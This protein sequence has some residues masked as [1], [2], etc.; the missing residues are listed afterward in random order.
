VHQSTLGFP[1]F[2]NGNYGGVVNLTTSNSTTNG[3]VNST[4]YQIGF[5][6]KK[7]F[8]YAISAYG[9]STNT[10]DLT[11]DIGFAFSVS[12]KTAN[13]S[14]TCTGAQ[15]L[16]VND[17]ASFSQKAFS[18][19]PPSWIPNI[20]NGIADKDYYYL[21]VAALPHG[22]MGGTQTASL[23]AIQIVETATL[24]VSPATITTN[25]SNNTPQTFIVNNPNGI[26][27]IQSYTWALGQTG[28]S[29]GWLY[30]GSAAPTTIT[31]S[32]NSIL[33][34]PACRSRQ[35]NI[36]V[37][38][39]LNGSSYAATNLVQVQNVPGI[40]TISGT[41]V[42]CSGSANYSVSNNSC[43]LPLAWSVSPTGIA[44]LSCN[45]CNTTTLTRVSNGTVTLSAS[46]GSNNNNCSSG[47]KSVS[48]GGAS[49]PTSITVNSS[50]IC[51]EYRFTT[52]QNLN[53]T[54]FTWQ[55]H[56]NPFSNNEEVFPNLPYTTRLNIDQGNGSYNIGVTAVNACGSSSIYYITT[57]IT[58]G[59]SS[60]AI[61][62]SPDPTTGIV[63][64]LS[65]IPALT[66]NTEISKVIR[67]SKIYHIKVIG[68]MGNLLKQFSYPSGITKTNIDLSSLKD[69]IYILQVYDNV[70]WTSKQFV[71]S[72]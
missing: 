14:T 37:S 58:C 38:A 49:Q 67:G 43:G 18:V 64:V 71:I 15:L 1:S 28:V 16:S 21:I 19:S 60:Q 27:G 66:Q 4:Q 39:T 33:L 50:D 25:C 46:I 42:I 32:S 70:S 11:A 20:V 51:D 13:T 59:L 41:S 12:A 26:S 52:N 23:Q 17:E 48:V 2:T 7:G 54:S 56:K 61:K 8:N 47:S 53:A 57:N 72:K 22:A 69:G 62:I 29:S 55:F 45:N 36:S 9:Y 3:Y 35:S 6:F 5:H 24:S 30:N 34:T 65:T 40:L 68:Q 31:T 63:T 44:T 10:V